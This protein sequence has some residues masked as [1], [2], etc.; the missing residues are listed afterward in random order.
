MFSAASSRFGIRVR[1]RSRHRE[2]PGSA[3]PL[4]PGLASRLCSLPR[5]R[6]GCPGSLG[7]QRAGG[8][9][10][11]GHEGDAQHQVGGLHVAE[12]VDDHPA[13]A[14]QV[15]DIADPQDQ[16]GV[17]QSEEDE[18]GHPPVKQPGHGPPRSLLIRHE[19]Q[20]SRPEDHAE[21]RRILPSNKTVMKAFNQ[22]LM[23]VGSLLKGSE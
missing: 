5:R 8:E 19:Q 10:H 13:K 21:Q 2:T 12:E 11:D 22:K 16:V 3:S 9:I 23:L 18:P 4:T 14:V 17:D 6:C 15:E 7:K 1:S 20:D